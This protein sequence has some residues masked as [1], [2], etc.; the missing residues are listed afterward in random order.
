MPQKTQTQ[1]CQ[2]PTQWVWKCQRRGNNDTKTDPSKCMN[3]GIILN[4][5]T[6]VRHRSLAVF[7][8]GL[9]HTLTIEAK[10]WL[11]Q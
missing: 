11:C 7:E 3:E 1:K 6:Q 8:Q 10:F 9:V 5:F 2:C 4:V